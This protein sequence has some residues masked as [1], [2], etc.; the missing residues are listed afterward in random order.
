M[1]RKTCLTRLLVSSFLVLALVQQPVAASS[2]V[3]ADPAQPLPEPIAKRLS[4]SPKIKP[5][6]DSVELAALYYYAKQGEK[7]RVDREIRR[8]SV[9]FP[10]FTV[11]E[12]LFRPAEEKRVDES[13]LWQLYEKDDYAA[14]DGE[15][16]R[17]ASENPGWEP[18]E[19]FQQKL[20][21]RKQR[22]EMSTGA[23]AQDWAAV[24]ASGHDLDPKSETEADLLWMLIDAYSQNSMLDEASLIYQ[25]MLFRP[26]DRRLS[27]DVLIATLQKAARDFPATELRQV[28]RQL[29]KSP[30]IAAS[31][32]SLQL[33][34]MRREL[35]DYAAS[36]QSGVEP[37]PT[38][39]VAVRRAAD[40]LSGEKDQILLGWYYLKA[41]Q[42]KEAEVWFRRALSSQPSLEALKG[43]CFTLLQDDRKPEAFQAVSANLGL[44]SQDWESLLPALSVAFT[45][46]VGNLATPQVVE[47][48]ANA[49]Q[50]A[51]SPEHAELLG[52]YAYNALQFDSAQA[53]FRKSFD[54]K[55]SPTALKGQLL[56]TLQRKDK[57]A[58]R[59]LEEQFGKEYP[60]VFTEL[61]S[62]KA[63][64]GNKGQN[65]A[66]PSEQAQPQYVVSFKARRYGDCLSDLARKASSGG[67]DANAE[68]VRGWCSLSLNRIS[69]ARSAFEIAVRNGGGKGDDAL[70]GL[71]LTLLRAKLTADAEALLARGGL[72]PARDA[73]LRSELLWQKARAAFDQK[74]YADVLAALDTRL[75]ITP[76]AVGMT[77]MRA[78]AH[79]HLGNLGQARA[80]FTALNQVVRDAANTRGLT[81]IEE[82][83]GIWR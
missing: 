48:F 33:D 20:L 14:I 13:A 31:S 50:A 83:M 39:L 66:V 49:I 60:Q 25:G 63:P 15:I 73:E 26:D 1:T 78:W 23:K 61:K 67:L 22:F 57:A 18:S 51:Q 30:S 32:Q 6:P 10:D 53:W 2:L 64:L 82:R 12:D 46:K 19:D 74:R 34:L 41:G 56:A 28:I 45:E 38:T 68:L 36:T 9:K 43:L 5:A 7:E 79:Y 8:I 4:P 27:D 71:G 42:K 37:L 17:I 54:W 16:S 29:S 24:I 21:R 62:E 76:E 44:A 47:A 11:P 69:D 52:R 81:A 77:Q 80:I 72:T 58:Y 3:P 70:Y 59:E 65:V 35:A 40:Q 55:H 75:Q